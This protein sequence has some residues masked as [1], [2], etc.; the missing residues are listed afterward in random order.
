LGEFILVWSASIMALPSSLLDH[1][2]TLFGDRLSAVP[3][4]R[5]RHGKGESLHDGGQPDAV[6]FARSTAEVSAA[7]AAC[8]KHRV[9]MVAYGSGTSLEGHVAALDG[10]LC[11][12]LSQMDAI[13]AVRAEDMDATVQA[14]VTHNRLNAYLR[15]TGLFFPV[16]IGAEAT[17]GGMVACRAAGT[18]SMRYGGMRE[19]VLSLQVVL[20]DGR[21]VRTASRARK[22][23]AGYDLTRLFIGSEGTL[24]IV[25]EV[26]VKLHGVP[27][28]VSAAA[29]SFPSVEAAAA[30]AAAAIQANLPLVRIEF[31][32]PVF[33][34][35]VVS[36]A[37]LDYRVAPTL[38]FELSGAASAM[39]ACSE[40][41]K[42]IAADHQCLDFRWSLQADERAALWAA[43]QKAY[44]A[45]IQQQPGKGVVTVDVAVPMSRLAEA[46]LAA[47]SDIDASP[48]TGG[49]H[50]DVGDG[51]LFAALLVDPANPAELAEAE[52]LNETLIR[53][54]IDMDGT[55][56]GSHGVGY[57]KIEHLAAELGE[58]ADVLRVVKAAFDPANLLNPGKIVRITRSPV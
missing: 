31:L 38:L 6:V 3:A 54:A 41:L 46:I 10:G 58:G 35:A 23:A 47:R 29:C 52:R 22:S 43:R 20:A 44:L 21:V 8:T 53:R 30:A 36:R 49:I 2:S 15:D 18:N 40:Q 13:V 45:L 12:D 19:N 50:A 16:N 25:T 37:Q 55:C 27:E 51:N 7:A 32:D 1:L 34:E 14:G 39:P 4:I 48:L 56:T 26:T 17:L 11:I 5:D 57:G 24:G 9:P 33:M 42:A 28:A